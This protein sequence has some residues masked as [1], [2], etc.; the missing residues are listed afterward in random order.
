MADTFT[1]DELAAYPGV[2]ASAATLGVVAG[3]FNGLVAELVAEHGPTVAY[4]A[5]VKSIALGA[6]A[7][8]MVNPDGA[9]TASI[10]LDDYKET[11]VYSDGARRERRTGL[12]FTS[13]DVARLV[14]AITGVDAPPARS[15]RLSVPGYSGE[16]CENVRGWLPA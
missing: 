8:S 15:L 6:A 10:Q 3:I 16:R 4:P 2:A 11:R 9:T 1:A 14:A 7:D 12:G 13:A 5:T